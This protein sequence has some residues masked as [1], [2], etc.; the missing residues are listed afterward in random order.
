MTDR[1][2]FVRSQRLTIVNG[3]LVFAVIVVVLQLWLLNASMN[4]FLAGDMSTA[5]PAALVSL[6]C[7]AVNLGLLKVLY[8]LD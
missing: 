6:A 5:V 8:R 3:A 2:R 1:N 7:L 4:A